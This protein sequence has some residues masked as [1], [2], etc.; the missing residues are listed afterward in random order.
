MKRVGL[1]ILIATLI[2]LLLVIS[3]FRA[4]GDTFAYGK[5]VIDFILSLVQIGSVILVIVVVVGYALYRPYR[6][7]FKGFS[8]ADDKQVLELNKLASRELMKQLDFMFYAWTKYAN[9]NDTNTTGIDMDELLKYPRILIDLLKKMTTNLSK[10][11]FL[12]TCHLIIE[13]Y[14]RSICP[15]YSKIRVIFSILLAIRRAVGLSA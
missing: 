5:I 14:P 4:G 11:I 3:I 1:L 8:N 15:R 13:H 2:L 7:V 9:R 12:Y 10:L 6:F